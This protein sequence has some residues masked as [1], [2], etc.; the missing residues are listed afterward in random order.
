MINRC[1][2]Q[3]KFFYMYEVFWLMLKSISNFQNPD[4]AWLNHARSCH[5]FWTVE[6]ILKP[7][8]WKLI[9]IK[10]PLQPTNL[11]YILPSLVQA[12]LRSIQILLSSGLSQ[13]S[14]K[15][16]S[17]V[18]LEPLNIDKKFKRLNWLKLNLPLNCPTFT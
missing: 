18:F 10:F 15:T 5:I 17:T 16:K 1:W 3:M 14:S 11:N 8:K 13:A 9:R 12:K 6:H 4:S 7:E 2:Q